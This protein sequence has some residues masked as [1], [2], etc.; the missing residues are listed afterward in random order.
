MGDENIPNVRAMAESSTRQPPLHLHHE[1]WVS[2]ARYCIKGKFNYFNAQ[3]SS[4]LKEDLEV[5]KCC[6]LFSTHKV[7]EMNRTASSLDQHLSCIPFLMVMKLP[8]YLAGDADLDKE[9]D[10]VKWWKINASTLPHWSTVA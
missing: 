7:Q 1:Q 5:F 9:F 4:N 2:Y 6:R 10:P 8:T 3:L